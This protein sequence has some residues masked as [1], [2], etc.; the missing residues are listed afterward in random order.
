MFHNAF[1]LF[2]FLSSD[3]ILP[4]AVGKTSLFLRYCN[5]TFND[6]HLSTVQASFLS[7][8]LNIEGKRVT[9]AIWVPIFA[10]FIA[11]SSLIK[12]ISLCRTQL[13][14]KGVKIKE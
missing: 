12:L 3:I 8:R 10:H 11:I 5:N 14:R 13:D 7:K 4:G 1:I 6:S 9:L 2:K